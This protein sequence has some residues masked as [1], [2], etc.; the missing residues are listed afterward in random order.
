[1]RTLQSSAKAQMLNAEA[2][3]PKHAAESG[4]TVAAYQMCAG[5]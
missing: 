4:N 1:M 2:K 5:S 3:G